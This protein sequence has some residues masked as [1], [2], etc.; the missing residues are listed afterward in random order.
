MNILTE[1]LREG[2]TSEE[3][4]TLSVHCF[5]RFI[6]LLHRNEPSHCEN[7]TL[8]EEEQKSMSYF[9]FGEGKKYKISSKPWIPSEF[10]KISGAA[11]CRQSCEDR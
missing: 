10:E 4:K 11:M 9:R 2:Q 8:Y 7:D 5:Q 1:Y 3:M 6:T